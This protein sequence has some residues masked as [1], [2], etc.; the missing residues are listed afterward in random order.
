M[1]GLVART[2]ATLGAFVGLAVPAYSRER[3][4]RT[5]CLRR[6]LVTSPWLK[7]INSSVAS[8]K[9]EWVASERGR[10]LATFYAAHHAVL[11]AVVA[12][13]GA[14]VYRGADGAW[15]FKTVMDAGST[16]RVA[17]GLPLSV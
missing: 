17:A 5:G 6:K 3:P 7:T 1:Y 2:Q 12:R 10:R 15:H 16:A 4:E 14:V 13:E 8:T 11:P 9:A